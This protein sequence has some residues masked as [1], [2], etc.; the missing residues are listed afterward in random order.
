MAMYGSKVFQDW[1][2]REIGDSLNSFY[3]Y[4]MLVAVFIVCLVMYFLFRIN[5]SY[6]KYRSLKHREVLEWIW[7]IVPMV[8]LAVL[9][10]PS[11]RNLYL[12]NHIGEPKWS[13]K[14]VGHQWYWTYEFTN[15]KYD[16]VVLESYMD[17]LDSDEF[18]YRLLDVDQRMVAP[19][20]TQMRVLVSSVDVLHSFALP[21]CMLKIDA[22][23]GRMTQTPLLIDKSGVCYGQ[24]SE[25][26]GVNHSFMPIVVEFIPMDVFLK[27][28]DVTGD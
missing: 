20:N 1:I 12:M 15:K 25:L 8:I 18:K 26:C 24:C 6:F 10:V 16:Q 2:Y 27:W 22:I 19:V 14:A 5:T 4:M 28:L 7:T 23:P 21:S 9:W 13:F 17:N 11:V 3:H